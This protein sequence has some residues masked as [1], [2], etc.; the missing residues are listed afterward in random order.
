MQPAI[1]DVSTVSVLQDTLH[2]DD[3]QCEHPILPN[4]QAYRTNAF[5]DLHPS[6]NVTD[7]LRGSISKSSLD[8]NLLTALSL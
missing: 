1:I 3:K 7:V 8:I 5:K 6:N 4:K 2:Y